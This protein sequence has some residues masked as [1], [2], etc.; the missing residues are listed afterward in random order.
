MSSL[1]KIVKNRLHRKIGKVYSTIH[2]KGNTSGFQSLYEEII[3]F[4]RNAT[5]ITICWYHFLSIRW[6]KMLQLWL[7]NVMQLQGNRTLICS[8]LK[9][10]VLPTLMEGNMEQLSKL[11]THLSS[12]PTLPF[13]EKFPTYL[14]TT[15]W[16][17]SKAIH[18][19]IV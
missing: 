16:C 18:Y 4:K 11:Q 19:S 6:T 17:K 14:H 5:K 9:Y 10:K 12:D 7:Y 13:L 2:R 15:K 3:T 1:L 8:W